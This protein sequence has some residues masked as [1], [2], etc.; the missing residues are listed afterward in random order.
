MFSCKMLQ[1]FTNS[2]RG[3]CACK[4][5]ESIRTRFTHAIEC[6]VYCWLMHV[7]LWAS[8][9][10]AYSLCKGEKLH[11][12]NLHI[13]VKFFRSVKEHCPLDSLFNRDQQK[14]TLL[15]KSDHKAK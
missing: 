13:A 12:S 7:H 3:F 6:L 1:D 15:Y 11:A 10:S 2:Q 8:N 5:L 4:N 14:Y 9:N